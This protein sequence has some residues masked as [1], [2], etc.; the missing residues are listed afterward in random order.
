MRHKL[1]FTLNTATFTLHV[2]P[3][4]IDTAIS[5]HSATE[6][7]DYLLTKRHQLDAR[8]AWRPEYKTRERIHRSLA[9]LRLLAIPAS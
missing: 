5:L 6:W 2:I 9:D 8:I 1:T 4:G 7:L 3:R